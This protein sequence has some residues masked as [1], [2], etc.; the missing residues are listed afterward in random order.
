MPTLPLNSYDRLRALGAHSSA[1][2]R[3]TCGGGTGTVAARRETKG[4]LSRGTLRGDG[5][6][7]KAEAE[8]ERG[9]FPF[10]S[11]LPRRRRRE[12][13]RR[14]GLPPLLLSG[15][16][17]RSAARWG[18]PIQRELPRH[19]TPARRQDSPAQRPPA[20]NHSHLPPS[21]PQLLLPLS[22]RASLPS[23]SPQHNAQH[24]AQRTTH[25]TRLSER[26]GVRDPHVE[27]RLRR[28]GLEVHDEGGV[29]ERG[30]GVLGDPSAE[31]R[32]DRGSR[33]VSGCGYG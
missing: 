20:A 30:R 10:S 6:N 1:I 32:L 13:R 28:R 22:V 11:P 24:N 29:R 19:N 25:N 23:H 16:P 26:R 14:R 27:P 21:H 12:Q 17:R 9:P 2:I 15:G 3:S 8:A 18:L 31:V 4:A 7:S 33:G 5:R